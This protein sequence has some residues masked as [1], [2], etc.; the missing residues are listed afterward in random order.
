MYRVCMIVIAKFSARIVSI[1][2]LQPG[3]SDRTTVL[4][5]C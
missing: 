3:S 2:E 1:R 5:H 4:S